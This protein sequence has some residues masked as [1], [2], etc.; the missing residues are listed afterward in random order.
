MKKGDFIGIKKFSLTSHEIV[1][2]LS[3]FLGQGVAIY[4]YI[5]LLV[6]NRLPTF[7]FYCPKKITVNYNK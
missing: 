1:S 7:Q 5:K 2:F 3:A 6:F 4:D